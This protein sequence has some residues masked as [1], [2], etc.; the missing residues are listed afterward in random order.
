M[1]QLSQTL[2]IPAEVSQLAATYR[3]GT[4]LKVYRPFSMA[5]VVFAILCLA[6]AVPCIIAVGIAGISSEVT[7]VFG[8]IALLLVV[9]GLLL[10]FVRTK[11]ATSLYLCTDG[12]ISLQ[13]GQAEAIRWDQVV[14]VIRQYS[15]Y[16]NWDYYKLSHSMTGL[17]ADLVLDQTPSG[18]WNRSYSIRWLDLFRA[19]GTHLRLDLMMPLKYREFS[20]SIEGEITQR[21]LPQLTAAYDAGNPV[22]FPIQFGQL[23]SI[24][25]STQGIT[26]RGETLPWN[27]LK[28]VAVPFNKP[29]IEIKKEGKFLSWKTI[30]VMYMPNVCV[31]AGLIG[32]ATGG[33]KVKG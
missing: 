22:E 25:V 23:E 9:L 30:K 18:E 21:L 24:T 16:S 10:L 27:E 1:A 31:F 7:V 3:V 29:F 2:T 8:G 11:R 13:K 6:F 32:Y 4:P 33:Q 12:V 26:I 14:S 15:A 5:R 17:L 28:Q 20:R 19:D